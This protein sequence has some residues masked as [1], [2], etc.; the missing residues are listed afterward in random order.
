MVA[1]DT[2]IRIFEKLD[3]ISH[4]LSKLSGEFAGF[5]R[6]SAVKDSNWDFRLKTIEKELEATRVDVKQLREDRN[7]LKGILI[8]FGIVCTFIGFLIS[9]LIRMV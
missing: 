8:G 4:R 9:N 2:T 3:E 5:E 1:E 6:A 7:K